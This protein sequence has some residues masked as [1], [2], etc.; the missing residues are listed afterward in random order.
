[1]GHHTYAGSEWMVISASGIAALTFFSI[2]SQIKSC[3][4]ATDNLLFTIIVI[5]IKVIAPTALTLKRLTEITPSTFFAIIL[6]FQIN[7][8]ALHQPEH[9]LS[10][11]PT[12][13]RHVKQ[14]GQLRWRQL[15]QPW[16]FPKKQILNLQ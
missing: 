1:M 14:K 7:P 2:S 8:G 9:L 6:I 15:H 12:C 11:C 4:F 10:F 13:I 16:Q 5:S 3:A